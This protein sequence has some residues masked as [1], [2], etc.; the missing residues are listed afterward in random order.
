MLADGVDI[1][2]IQLMLGHASIQQTQHYPAS[3]G[4]GKLI[5]LD[6]LPE[7][8]RFVPGNMKVW[9]RGRATSGTCSCGAGRRDEVEVSLVRAGCARRVAVGPTVTRD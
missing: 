5:G 6:S 2:I 8:P 4:I 3:R 7:C 1:G 9:L